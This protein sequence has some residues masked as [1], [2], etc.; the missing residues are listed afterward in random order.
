[1]QSNNIY[2]LVTC[3]LFN[4]I[5]SKMCLNHDSDGQSCSGCEECA[6][7]ETL[8]S[9][10]QTKTTTQQLE[11]Q[12]SSCRDRKRTAAV[13][14]DICPPTPPPSDA[15][16]L[17]PLS[18]TDDSCEACDM[19]QEVASPPPK[20]TSKLAQVRF[21]SLQSLLNVFGAKWSRSVLDVQWRFF[22][23]GSVVV[24]IPVWWCCISAFE[25][26]FTHLAIK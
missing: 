14:S 9:F 3:T 25:N 6:A 20:K 1:M 8:L 24:Q 26:Y 16:S 17:S 18:Q 22:N 13:L 10:S 23:N 7:V 19:M 4:F 2:T 21:I 11:S 5:Q 12:T 15:G